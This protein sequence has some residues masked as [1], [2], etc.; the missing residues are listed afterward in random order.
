MKIV[1]ALI[2]SIS[3]VKKSF[4]T[5]YVY[6]HK[7]FDLKTGASSAEESTDIVQTHMIV[8][9]EIHRNNTVEMENNTNIRKTEN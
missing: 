7:V 9:A 3:E 4:I 1:S 5:K 6:T 8:H 2:Y